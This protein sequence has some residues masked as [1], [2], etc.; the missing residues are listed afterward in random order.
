MGV[1]FARRITLAQPQAFALRLAALRQIDWVVYAKPPFGGPEQVL[2]YLA[3]YTHRA[4][5]ANSRRVETTDE[6]VALSYA[7]K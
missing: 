6:E 3:R 7:G 1:N 4:A 5:I 2:G